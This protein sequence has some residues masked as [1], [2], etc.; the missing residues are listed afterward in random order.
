MATILLVE[1]NAMIRDM[2]SRWLTRRGYQVIPADNGAV[3]LAQAR[4]VRPDVILMDMSMP[5]V[6][7]WIATRTLKTDPATRSIPIIGLSAHAMVGDSE[8]GLSA[9]CDAYFTK[10]I[11]FPELLAQI[12]LFLDRGM[13][14]RITASETP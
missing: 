5:V 2:I 3:G 12:Q 9:G 8:K 7:G 11:D 4:E 14:D 1:D 6:D 10:P 13:P